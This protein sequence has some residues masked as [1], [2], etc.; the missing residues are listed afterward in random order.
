MWLGCPNLVCKS[1]AIKYEPYVQCV[2]SW[3]GED[4]NQP[5]HG[6]DLEGEEAKDFQLYATILCD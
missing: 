4:D 3:L 1:L 6:L 5:K 2:Y